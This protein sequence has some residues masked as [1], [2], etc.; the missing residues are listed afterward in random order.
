MSSFQ[1]SAP[2]VAVVTL[3]ALLAITAYQHSELGRLERTLDEA[4]A[5]STGQVRTSSGAATS[6]FE[7][8]KR[9]DRKIVALEAD[10]AATRR[11]LGQETSAQAGGAEVGRRGLAGGEGEAPGRALPAGTM[12]L[13]L[14]DLE[15]EDSPVRA[16]L[17]ELVRT[18]RE[19][20]QTE[21]QM[22]RRDRMMEEA[23]EDFA[24]FAAAHNITSQQQ[25]QIL[26]RIKEERA[27]IFDLFRSRRDGNMSRE[28]IREQIQTIRSETDSAVLEELD[29]SQQEAYRE[30]RE[31]EAARWNN[32]GGRGGRGGRDRSR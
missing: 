29:S 31:E 15:D 20:Q 21:R 11:A 24:E 2:Y 5:S 7:E 4:Y 8:I 18:E 28:E 32:R 14:D 9:L 27:Q 13:V 16:Q 30:K 26:P 22:E 10:L 25:A 1:K 12:P 17:A 19:K 3:V 6:T 23:E